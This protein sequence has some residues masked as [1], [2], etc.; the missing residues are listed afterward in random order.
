M[1]RRSAWVGRCVGVVG[2]VAVSVTLALSSIDFVRLGCGRVSAG[3][4][5]AAG[6][7]VVDGDAAL[8]RTILEAMN[9]MF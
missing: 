3:E 6:G 7:V 9:F 1:Q 2:I 5:E 4:L 8:G